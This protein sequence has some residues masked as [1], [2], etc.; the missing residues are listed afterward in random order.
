[1]VNGDRIY[2]V[3]IGSRMKPIRLENQVVRKLIEYNGTF[4]RSSNWIDRK[5]IEVLLVHVVTVSV[6]RTGMKNIEPAL[7]EFIRG[8]TC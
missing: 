7:I 5:F 6:I 3:E 1:M 4:L 2:L 8:K